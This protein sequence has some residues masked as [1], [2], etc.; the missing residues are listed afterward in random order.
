MRRASGTDVPDTTSGFRAYNREAALQL[1]VVS[2]FT[3]TLESLIQAGK[4]LVAIDHVPVGTNPPDRAVAALPAPPAPTC[5]ATRSRSFAP[6]RCTSRCACSRSPPLVLALA[7]LAA[8]TPF[9]ADWILSGDSSGHIQSLILGAVLAIAAVQ[10]FALGVVGDALAGQRVMAQRAFERIR[11]VELSLGIEPSH[12]EPGPAAPTCRTCEPDDRR[13]SAGG[14][15]TPGPDVATPAGRR[16]SRARVDAEAPAAERRA[17]AAGEAAR[18]YGR[19]VS[20]L[21][22]AVGAT[23]VHHLPVLRARLAQPR[24]GRLR[25]TS[26]RSGRPSS[27]RSRRSTGRSSSCCRARSPSGRHAANPLGRAVAGRGDDPGSVAAD[28]AAICL[29][30]RGP[31]EDELLSGNSTLYWILVVSV[32]R[33]RGARYFARGFFAGHRRFGLYS[34]LLLSDRMHAVL[35]RAAR[36]PSGSPSGH[37]GDRARDRR[38]RRCV[39]LTLVPAVVAIAWRG[40]RRIEPSPSPSPRLPSRAPRGAAGP[41]FTLAHGGGFAAAVLLIMFSEQLFLNAGPLSCASPR[42][43]PRPAFIFNVLMI[44]RAPLL[45][46]PGGGDEPPPPPHPAALPAPTRRRGG[47]P[48]LG[49]VTSLAVVGFAA[50][51]AVGRARRRAGADADRLRRQVLLRPRRAC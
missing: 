36:W 32:A 25:R 41:E 45:A 51:V 7:A 26:R 14:E 30:L 6:T 37:D 44:A 2:N 33:L 13:G 31:L 23:G 20:M 48:P 3:Y 28:G 22:V 4:M 49:P 18:R 10:M 34:A 12:Y 50:V 46:V 40:R 15:P 43:P 42:A 47:V 5:A 39:S 16:S 19:T 29:A 24:Q 11:R 17:D 35:F 1:Q 27:S 8:W 21:S 9:L 38:R